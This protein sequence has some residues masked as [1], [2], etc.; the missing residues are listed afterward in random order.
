M[1][2]EIEKIIDNNEKKEPF[3]SISIENIIKDQS[4]PSFTAISA[5]PTNTNYIVVGTSMGHKIDITLV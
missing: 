5:H 2:F 1:S 4:N 3:R